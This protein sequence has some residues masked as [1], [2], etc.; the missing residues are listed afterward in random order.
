[1]TFHTDIRKMYNSVHL[2][3]EHWC[4]QRYIWQNELD[5]RKLSEEKVAATMKMDL[6][7]LVESGLNWDDILRDELGHISCQ[8]KI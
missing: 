1:M 6:Y 4:F 5:Q 2:K 3:E 7:M 8:V